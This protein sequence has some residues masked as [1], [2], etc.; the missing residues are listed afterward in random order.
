MTSIRGQINSSIAV[1]KTVGAKPSADLSTPQ[2]AKQ[3]R[4]K[5]LNMTAA[6]VKNKPAIFT[7]KYRTLKVGLIDLTSIKDRQ[8]DSPIIAHNTTSYSTQRRIKII[9]PKHKQSTALQ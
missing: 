7:S 3:K 4:N 2:S 8:T 5:A 6:I 9:T 1:N